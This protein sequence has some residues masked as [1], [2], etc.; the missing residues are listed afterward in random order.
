MTETSNAN[1]YFTEDHE[2][3]VVNDDETGLVGVST[4]AAKQLGEV[5][6]VELPAVGTTVT[7]GS[8]IA[9]VES[10]KAASDVFAPVSGEILEVNNDLESNP[11]IVN[12]SPE[13][14]GWLYKLKLS[15]VNELEGMMNSES[16]SKFCQAL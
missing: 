13:E 3:I 6:Y 9:V 10:V 8:E 11:E 14:S 5:V 4:Y 15:N 7:N 1:R 2:W 12:E 16:Y